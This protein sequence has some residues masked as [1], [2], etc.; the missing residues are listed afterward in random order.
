MDWRTFQKSYKEQ[1]LNYGINLEKE[2]K[3]FNIQFSETFKK[4]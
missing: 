1:L 4:C 2:M 3:T